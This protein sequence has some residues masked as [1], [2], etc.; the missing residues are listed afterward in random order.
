[1]KMLPL[2][3]LR[4]RGIPFT[5][6]HIHRLVRLGKFPKPIKL[7]TGTNGRNVWSSDEVDTFLKNCIAKRDTAPADEE[8]AA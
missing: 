7:G 4:D 1:M 8:A 3:D 2:R 5:R 6:Q